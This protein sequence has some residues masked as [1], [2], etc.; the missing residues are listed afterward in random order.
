MKRTHRAHSLRIHRHEYC[1]GTEP[2]TLVTLN[3]R[4]GEARVDIFAPNTSLHSG[5]IHDPVRTE[6]FLIP[7]GQELGLIE[8]GELAYSALAAQAE[9][10]P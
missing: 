3:P 1:G 6:Q 8:I 4:E 10:K 2:P 5:N 9:A 7:E